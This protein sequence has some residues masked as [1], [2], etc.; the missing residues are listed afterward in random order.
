MYLGDIAFSYQVIKEEALL[1]SIDFQDYFKH[2]LIHAILHL[3]GYNHEND[4]EA[5]IMETIEIEILDSFG[6]ESPY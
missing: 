5:Q 6:I 3:I 1:K 2:L 4:E